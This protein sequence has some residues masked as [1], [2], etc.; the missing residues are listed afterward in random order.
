MNFSLTDNAEEFPS[1]RCSGHGPKPAFPFL[2]VDTDGCFICKAFP[3]ANESIPS[4]IH[5][6]IHGLPAGQ[7][8]SLHEIRFMFQ[9][10][11][12]LDTC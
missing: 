9:A 10:G 3:S 12:A 11:I 4:A 1:E 2:P 6:S 5:E 7:E 8:W